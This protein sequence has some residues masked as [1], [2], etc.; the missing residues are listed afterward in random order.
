MQYDY[1]VAYASVDRGLAEELSWELEDLDRVVFLDSANLRAA[2]PWDESLATGLISSRAIVVLVS[3]QTAKA[4]YQRE[5]VARAIGEAR[6]N[7]DRKVVPVMLLGATVADIPYG[8]TNVQAINGAKP[9]GMKRVA[10]TLNGQLP[11]DKTE[12]I[13][14]VRYAYYTLG[15]ALRLNRVKQWSLVLEAAHIP[16]NTFFLFHG[17]HDQNVGLFLERIQ[18]FFSQELA[19]A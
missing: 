16:E 14:A 17:P 4:Y 1:F 10:R 18:R 3:K 13:Q 9:G 15:A 7:P 5:E 12:R 6:P 19:H 11:A 2:T 8:L